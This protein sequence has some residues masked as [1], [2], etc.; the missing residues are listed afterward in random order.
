[1]RWWRS[2]SSASSGA[3]W[4]GKEF[5]TP[6]LLERHEKGIKIKYHREYDGH[7]CRKIDVQVTKKRNSLAIVELLNALY[8]IMKVTLKMFLLL[9]KN[10]FNMSPMCWLLRNPESFKR[11]IF[12]ISFIQW[13]SLWCLTKPKDASHSPHMDNRRRPTTIT[14][15]DL[16]L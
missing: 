2:L 7:I 8:R 5:L 9:K 11:R 12:S 10:F 3:S 16:R 6:L 4:A 15:S 1:M 14:T 13:N